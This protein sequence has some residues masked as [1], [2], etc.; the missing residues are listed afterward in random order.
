MR[1]RA[2]NFFIFGPKSFSWK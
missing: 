2:F 1:K